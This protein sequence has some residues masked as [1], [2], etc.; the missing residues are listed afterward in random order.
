MR[1]QTNL[2]D[3]CG[4]ANK[5]WHTR[6]YYKQQPVQSQS[7]FW[8]PAV[9]SPCRYF[10]P[11]FFVQKWS[12]R[13]RSKSFRIG[14]KLGIILPIGPSIMGIKPSNKNLTNLWI[15]SRELTYP[16]KMAFWRW[17]SFS[18]GGICYTLLEGIH[19]A[20]H[21]KPLQALFIPMGMKPKVV[22]PKCRQFDRQLS[23]LVSCVSSNFRKNAPKN[24]M[25][26]F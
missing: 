7:H 14:C 1:I 23:S 13:I 12:P 2:T 18:P 20:A 24:C 21:S 16:P 22:G 10:F 19:I 9:S 26:F 11:T 8:G 5:N 17:F 6:T 4:T 25:W 15:P 3:I